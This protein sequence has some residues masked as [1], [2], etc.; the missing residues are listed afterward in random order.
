LFDYT[1]S[2]TDEPA[3]TRAAREIER[4]VADDRSGLL[5]ANVNA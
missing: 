3:P 5:A 1:F 4:L 2:R